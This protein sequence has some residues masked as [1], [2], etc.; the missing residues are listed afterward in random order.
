MRKDDGSKGRKAT[1]GGKGSQSPGLHTFQRLLYNFN[2]KATTVMMIGGE[3]DC[4]PATGLTSYPHFADDKREVWGEL[5]GEQSQNVTQLGLGAARVRGRTLLA[6]HLSKAPGTKH[7]A[8]LQGAHFLLGSMEQNKPR[9]EEL[10]EAQKAAQ[11]RDHCTSLQTGYFLSISYPL[12]PAEGHWLC[13]HKSVQISEVTGRNTWPEN[14]R[15][16]EGGGGDG[17][18]WSQR[19][20]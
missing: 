20:R 2:S 4:V 1:G 11:E 8:Y 7:H 15:A 16:G 12:L 18:G 5:V 9:V 17:G 13:L 3:C 6:S 19:K 10:G 14:P